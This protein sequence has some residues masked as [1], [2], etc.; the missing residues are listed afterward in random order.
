M[1]FL[2]SFLSMYWNKIYVV[3]KFFCYVIK[4]IHRFAESYLEN[5][6]CISGYKLSQR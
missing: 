1:N 4:S 2:L 3:V 6:T 5:V